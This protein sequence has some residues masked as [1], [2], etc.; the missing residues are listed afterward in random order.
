[1]LQ[2]LRLLVFHKQLQLAELMQLKKEGT[3][4]IVSTTNKRAIPQ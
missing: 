4:T 3:H 1:M 2:K